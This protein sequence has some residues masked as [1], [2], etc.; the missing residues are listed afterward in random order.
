MTVIVW[1]ADTPAASA[2]LKVTE[3]LLAPIA[4][5]LIVPVLLFK[6]NPAGSDPEVMLHV[7]ALVPPVSFKVAL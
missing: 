7:Y 3:P 6:L 4:V 5:P 1:V 2:T